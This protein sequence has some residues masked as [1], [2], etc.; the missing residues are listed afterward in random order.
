MIVGITAVG[1]KLLFVET[2]QDGSLEI[3]RP[4]AKGCI[5]IWD[6]QN[7]TRSDRFVAADGGSDKGKVS[8]I[9]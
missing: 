2:R 8:E 1:T 5:R 4:E 9:L 7:E 3:I 6:E